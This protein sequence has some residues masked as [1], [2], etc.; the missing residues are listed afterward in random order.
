MRQRFR[1][2]TDRAAWLAARTGERSRSSRHESHMMP[3]S[4]KRALR[5]AA[6]EAEAHAPDGESAHDCRCSALA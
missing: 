6:A 5:G 3:A 2:L 4:P 1:V